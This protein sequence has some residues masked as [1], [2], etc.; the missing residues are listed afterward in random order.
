MKR[1]TLAWAAL[2]GALLLGGCV[3]NAPKVMDVTTGQSQ[4]VGT[5][6]VKIA[7]HSDRNFPGK[8]FNK[9]WVNSITSVNGVPV[10][11]GA[12]EIHAPAGQVTLAYKCMMTFGPRDTGNVETTGKAT[13]N[14]NASEKRYYGYVKGTQRKKDTYPNGSMKT[15]EGDC[16]LDSMSTENPRLLY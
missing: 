3:T 8:T 13:F 15:L 10:D 14:L 4:G 6:R 11:E 9:W 5:G 2:C 1:N 12:T 7:V 16:S